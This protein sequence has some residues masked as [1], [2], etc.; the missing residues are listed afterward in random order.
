MQFLFFLSHVGQ[1]EEGNMKEGQQESWAELRAKLGSRT[2]PTA[3]GTS[4]KVA[5][6]GQ[7]V[8]NPQMPGPT[9][10]FPGKR[11]MRTEGQS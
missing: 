11:G 2:S 4:R 3:K 6:P 10:A 9:A 8:A 5:V 1:Q 7:Q